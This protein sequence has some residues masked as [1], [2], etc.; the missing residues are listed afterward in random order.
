MSHI[1]LVVLFNTIQKLFCLPSE[2][3]LTGGCCICDSISAVSSVPLLTC[4][5]PWSES[6]RD[7]SEL[8]TYYFI[9]ICCRVC[10]ACAVWHSVFCMSLHRA[11][12]SGSYAKCL[13]VLELA[14]LTLLLS[15]SIRRVL[16]VYVGIQAALCTG[17]WSTAYRW[18]GADGS[19]FFRDLITVFTKVTSCL[20]QLSMGLFM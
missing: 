7:C 9:S 19:G 18:K 10:C 3:L 17:C 12:F 20:P 14:V 6:H 4:A 2:L 11:A 5:V 15:L 8:S 1:I 16:Q 13:A